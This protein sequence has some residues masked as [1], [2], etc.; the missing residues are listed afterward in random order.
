MK[1][2][3]V[4]YH[5]DDIHQF[6]HEKWHTPLFKQEHETPGSFIHGVMERLARYP[7]FVYALSE[8]PAELPLKCRS[9]WR[10]F[11][12]WWGGI[13]NYPIEDGLHDTYW[14]HEIAH[15]IHMHYLPDLS[16]SVFKT[17]MAHNEVRA[18]IASMFEVY[19]RYPQ[20][21]ALTFEHEILADRFLRDGEFM[22]AWHYDAD[23]V[24]EQLFLML[25]EAALR[26]NPGDPYEHFIYNYT[27]K[28][29]QWAEIWKS[30]Y[31]EVETAMYNFQA[32]IQSGADRV[33][34]MDG[35]MEWL[36]SHAI[37][38]GT[39]IPFLDEAIAYNA[40]YQD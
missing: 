3:R 25:R 7:M 11:S 37:T 1:D 14:L 20:L 12:V 39:D 40:V 13:H 24:R 22:K 30:R 38:R 28:N 9:E 19:F 8:H 33:L 5:S 23:S 16:L 17:K 27:E 26:P 34:V 4:L 32:D 18:N 36:Q 29:K 2:V 35:F 6:F 31:N 21:R 10:H 15:K